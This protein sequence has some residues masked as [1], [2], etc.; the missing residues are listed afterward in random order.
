MYATATVQQF[1]RHSA[2]VVP[3]EA[4]Q[5]IDGVDTVFVRDS[6]NQFRA[7]TVEAGR[8]VDGGVE[9]VEG[10]KPGDAVVVKG[11]FALKSQLLK[12]MIQDE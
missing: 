2:L 4:I 5:E 9:I 11:G 3:E 7:R 12:A 10:L 8:H 1:G 6:G